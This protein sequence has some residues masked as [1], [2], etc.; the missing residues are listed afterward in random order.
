MTYETTFW[1]V[2]ALLAAVAVFAVL[3]ALLSPPGAQDAAL[4]RELTREALSE[5]LRLLNDEKTAGLISDRIFEAS[6]ADVERRALE[7]MADEAQKEPR[8]AP[9]GKALTTAVAL[10]VVAAAFVLY[11]LLGSPNLINFVSEP[12]RP[13]IMRADGSLGSTEGLYNEESLAAYL[14]DN[15]KDER[16]WVLYARLLVKKQAWKQAAEAYGKAVARDGFVA[17]DSDVLTEYAASLIS[18]KTPQAYRES[19]GVLDRALA[20][21]EKHMPSHELYA[22]VSL[23]L[24]HWADARAHLEILLG[25]IDMNDPVYERL[26]QT[27]AYAA[28]RERA[29]KESKTEPDRTAP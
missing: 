7:E 19:L 15:A 25:A 5:Q 26:A 3:K 11:Q 4:G 16:A 22:I 18:Q 23:E 12:P 9:L 21:D 6:V 8:K 17:K 2:A 27:A 13:G 20:L 10:T 1:I 29:Q 28:E 14:K 24:E